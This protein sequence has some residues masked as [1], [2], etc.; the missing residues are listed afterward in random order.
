MDFDGARII[1]GGSASSLGAHPY[2]G[3]LVVLLTNGQQSV[4]G[5]TLISN[6]R[7]V[8]AAHCW[9]D[10][11]TSARQFTVVLASVRLFSGGVRI[12]TTR[13]ILHPFYNTQNYNYDV[14]VITINH[15]AYTS[16]IQALR[17]ATG[18]ATYVNNW[19]TAV[20]FGMTSDAQVGVPT[21]TVL[22][23]VNLQVITNAACRNYYG[24]NIVLDSTL[25]TDGG[26]GT[27]IC[28][29]DSGGPLVLNIIGFGNTLIGISSFGSIR[30]CQVG[31][32]SGFVRVALVN[33]W[34]RQQM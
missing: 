11:T 6:T 25:C 5:S 12:V 4:C 1:I 24:W 21:D 27:G 20:G 10:Q 18:S 16:N 15:V 32:P 19:P 22:R 17:L 3:G 33:S 26:R 29:G 8:T 31:A 13:V 23:Q 34:I 14:A 9:R 30:G 2:M 28:G 7:L